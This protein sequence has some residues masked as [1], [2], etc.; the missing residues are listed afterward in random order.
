MN[1][2]SPA[3]DKRHVIYITLMMFAVLVFVMFMA[4][5]F[6]ISHGDVGRIVKDVISL[7]VTLGFIN[8]WYFKSEKFFSDPYDTK[9]DLIDHIKKNGNKIKGSVVHISEKIYVKNNKEIIDS[10]LVV[11]FNKDGNKQHILLEHFPYYIRVFDISK[12]P[13]EEENFLKLSQY[14]KDGVIS[15]NKMDEEA[16][17]SRFEGSI[18]RNFEGNL[19]CEIYEYR[20]RYIIDDVPGYKLKTENPNEKNDIKGFYAFTIKIFVLYCILAKICAE[21]FLQ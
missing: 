15:F 7:I 14:K 9:Y 12:N 19:N 6:K 18:E 21:L 11:A 10:T 17:E 1:N 4:I 8:Y 16:V 2:T 5:N 13:V 3:K 20:G